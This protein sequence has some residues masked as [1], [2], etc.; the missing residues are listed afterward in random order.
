MKP[1]QVSL[2]RRAQPVLALLACAALAGPASAERGEAEGLTAR[3]HDAP[4]PA[5]APMPPSPGIWLLMAAGL[6]LMGVAVRRQAARR[7][8]APLDGLHTLPG[9]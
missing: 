5:A 4:R 8:S 1:L 9:C 6:G 2:P 7:E 3:F